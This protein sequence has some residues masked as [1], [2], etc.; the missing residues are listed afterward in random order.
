M[1]NLTI[2]VI[3]FFTFNGC[4]KDNNDFDVNVQ[5]TWQLVEQR[6]S[7][8]GPEQTVIIEDGYIYTFRG[9]NEITSSQ[10]ECSGTFETSKDEINFSFP[11]GEGQTSFTYLYSFRDGFLILRGT[12]CDEICEWKFEKVT[13]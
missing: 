4:S 5:G 8:G 12:T 10:F 9:E 2:F 13:N 3:I 7:E 6:F 1:K 11:C